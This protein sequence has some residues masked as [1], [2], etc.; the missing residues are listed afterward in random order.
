LVAISSLL[1]QGGL[2]KA[3]NQDLRIKK[4]VIPLLLLSLSSYSLFRNKYYLLSLKL[5][6]RSILHLCYLITPSL[7]VTRRGIDSRVS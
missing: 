6:M 7:V 5:S 3:I 4:E 2:K 1:Y